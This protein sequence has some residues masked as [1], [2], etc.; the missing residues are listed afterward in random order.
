MIEAWG[1]HLVVLAGVYLKSGWLLVLTAGVV[2][3]FLLDVV[4]IAVSVVLPVIGSVSLLVIIV[5]VGFVVA[6][7]AWWFERYWGPFYLWFCWYI[8]SSYIYS[9]VPSINSFICCVC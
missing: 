8:S 5:A 3:L 1:W 4:Y 6:W 9:I 2:A 7:L